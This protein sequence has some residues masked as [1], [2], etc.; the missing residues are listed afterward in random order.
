MAPSQKGMKANDVTVKVG[1][2][3]HGSVELLD[4]ISLVSMAY[5]KGLIVL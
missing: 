2:H 3:D 4:P 1:V 5:L